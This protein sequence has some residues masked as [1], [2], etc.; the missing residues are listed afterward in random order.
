LGRDFVRA[1][2]RNVIASISETKS[3]RAHVSKQAAKQKVA[4][5]ITLSRRIDRFAGAAP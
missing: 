2:R 5:A 4:D 3:R 1:A